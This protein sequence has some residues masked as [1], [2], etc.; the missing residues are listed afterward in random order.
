MASA[1][2]NHNQWLALFARRHYT[3]SSQTAPSRE[4]LVPWRDWPGSYTCDGQIIDRD[5]S[6]WS[7]PP[8]ICAIHAWPNISRTPVSDFSIADNAK[9]LMEIWWIA[10]WSSVGVTHNYAQWVKIEV[11]PNVYP[12]LNFAW[13]R[14]GSQN[15]MKV[16]NDPGT[17]QFKGL[18]AKI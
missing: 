14:R 6:R 12:M 17:M 3:L 10:A 18:L 2:D 11:M 15:Q 13:H 8:I 1:L 16:I 9:Y 4:T 5:W 7:S